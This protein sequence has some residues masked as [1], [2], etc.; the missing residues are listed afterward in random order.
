M[1]GRVWIGAVVV[2]LAGNALA[3]GALVVAS[4]SG[5][6]HHVVPDYY[7]KALAWDEEMA[8]DRAS[9]ALGWRAQLR[10][11]PAAGGTALDILL[12]DRDG[13][14]VAGAAVAVSAFHRIDAGNIHRIALVDAGGGHYRAQAP[15]RRAGVHELTVS[16][17]RGAAFWRAT[18]VDELPGASP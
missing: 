6:T 15:L 17:E 3:M 16:A 4:G 12:V 5:S 9:Q 18:L 13:A 10:A 11:E 7:R 2:L 14:P 1:S 8:V